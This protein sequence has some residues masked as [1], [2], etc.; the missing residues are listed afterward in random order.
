[1]LFFAV[2]SH[3]GHFSDS[4]RYWQLVQLSHVHGLGRGLFRGST[5]LLFCLLLAASAFSED[6][7]NAGPLYDSFDLTLDEGNRTEIFGPLFY[8]QV[9]ETQRTWAVPPL[10]SHTQDPGT[11]SE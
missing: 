5:I 3:V 6:L 1:M 8:S 7:W 9:K 10:F 2:K 11:E 4:A